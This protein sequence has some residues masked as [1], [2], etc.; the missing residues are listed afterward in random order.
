MSVTYSNEQCNRSKPIV[1]VIGIGYLVVSYGLLKG[2]GWTWTI[3]AI[4]T[5]IAI[6]IQIISVI[7]VGMFSA[8]FLSDM[9]ALVTSERRQA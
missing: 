5:I 4:L 6:V 3:T 2:R 7:S 1:L 9:H 8:S